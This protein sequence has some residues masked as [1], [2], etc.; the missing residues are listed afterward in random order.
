MQTGYSHGPLFAGRGKIFL[1]HLFVLLLLLFTANARTQNNF[2]FERITIDNGLSNNSI[3]SVLQTRDG[4]LW[5]ATKDGLNRFD[6]Q[7]FRIYKHNPAENNSL[8]ENYVMSLLE[9]RRGIL[10]V[11]TW[12]GGLCRYDSASDGFIAVRAKGEKDDFIQCLE[13]DGEGTLW[14]GTTEGGL[15]SLQPGSGL[16][17]C[18]SPDK[19]GTHYLPAR[20]VT[21]IETG[22]GNRLWLGTW[23]SGLLYLDPSA[24][25]VKVLDEGLSGENALESGSL[26]H[27]FND[28][29]S[30]LI[31]STLKGINILDFKTGGIRHSHKLEEKYPGFAS[32]NIGCSVRDSKGRIWIG[33]Y[34]Y[35]GLVMVRKLAEGACEYQHFVNED[36]NPASLTLDRIRCIYEDKKANIWIGTENGLNKLPDYLPFRQ[37]RHL[38]LRPSSLTGRVVSGFTMTGQDILW[39]GYGGGGF[40]RIE[41]KSGSIRHFAAEPGKANALSNDDVTSLYSSRDGLI[42]ISTMNGGLNRFDPESERFKSYYADGRAGSLRTN[43]IQQILETHD[44][45]FLVGT[46]SGLDIHD[47][48]NGTFS[49]FIPDLQDPEEKLPPQLS[50]NSLF[51]DSR[52]R[53]WI[54][55]WLEGL[56]CYNREKKTLKHYM[57]DP[58][59]QTAITSNKIIAIFEDSGG[60]LWFGT[61]SGGLCRLDES[62]GDFIAYTTINGLPNDVVFG[63][64]EDGESALWISTMRGLARLDPETG[65]IRVYDQLDGLVNNQFNW[66]ASYAGRDG[67][68]Y[69]GGINGFV[70]FHPLE[71]KTDTVPPQ[72]AITS[73]K[74]FNKETALHQTLPAIGNVELRHDQNFFSL[75]FTALDMAP[76][77]KHRYMYMLEGIDPFW[78]ES[79]NRTTAFYTD[80]HHGEFRFLV[81]ACNADD[82]WSEPV[83]FNI[84]VLPAWW[85][86]WWVKIMGLLT[87]F[88]IGILAAR[89]RLWHLLEIERIRLDIAR[90]LHDEMGSNLSSISVDSQQLMRSV[91]MPDNERE[92]A[93]DIYKTTNETIDSIRDIIWFINPKNDGGENL[94]FKMRERAA[95]MLAGR[96]WTFQVSEELKLD[97]LQLE[98]RRNIFL[99]FK[100]ALTNV[101][102]HSSAG[103]CDIR[104]QKSGNCLIFEICDN[105]KGF[106]IPDT[107]KQGGLQ[108]IYHRA[109][110]IGAEISLTSEI[111]KGTC[112]LLSLPLSKHLA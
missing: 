45:L 23:G 101:V 42:W 22:P 5:I 27:I 98:T 46:N 95:S 29:D 65:Y 63:I 59:D 51:E 93:T 71:I 108:N 40:D 112:L 67:T 103:S 35:Y 102:R 24:R 39:V 13:E 68:L 14:F 105:G 50:I 86:R 66:R 36:D 110:K 77:Q 91:Q 52:G 81:K 30:V 84:T 76:S 55:S 80:I 99:I 82:I 49:P 8:P 61:H 34:D 69:F 57:P 97:S 48:K 109:E 74:V 94:V 85:N 18:W 7:G 21:A 75:E 90:D 9:D 100:E 73:F 32:H 11:G 41:I 58:S 104:L 12:G 70:S 38:P 4:F 111:G 62:T 92:M 43:W 28:H 60:R 31:L 78:V 72:V 54:G 25:A 37:Y 44:G 6:G 2:Q 83:S 64:L 10:W 16:I 19:T 33:S 1:P 17:S 3:N 53:I 96:N 26:R 79:G 89:I 47:R 87:I 20:N 107:K 56:Y 88:G 106:N 15:F